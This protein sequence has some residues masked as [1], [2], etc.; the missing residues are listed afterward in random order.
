MT[1]DELIWLGAVDLGR[2]IRAGEITATHL[3]NAFLDRI[4]ALNQRLEAF[5]TIT[6]DRALSDAAAADSEISSGSWRGPLHGVPYCLKDIVQTAGI[7]TTAGSHILADWVPEADATVQT[8]LAAAGAVL[9]GKVNTH[10][11][12]FGATPRTFTAIPATRTIWIASPAV[13]PA[14]RR[15]PSRRRWPRSQSAA[16]RPDRSAFQRPFA[17]LPASSPAGG[18]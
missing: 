7:R 6:A 13:R 3:A 5:V 12:A 8:H 14:A 11:F 1:D 10:E 18:W 9:L 17:A 15:R 16:T 4:A 2:R